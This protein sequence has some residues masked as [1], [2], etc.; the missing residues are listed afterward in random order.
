MQHIDTVCGIASGQ[1]DPL[2]IPFLSTSNQLKKLI[3]LVSTPI[4]RVGTADNIARVLS[5]R[6]IKVEQVDIKDGDIWEQVQA[7]LEQVVTRCNELGDKLAF[8]ANGGTKPMA[9]AAFELCFNDNVPVFYVDGNDVQWLYKAEE[10]DLEGEIIDQSLNLNMYFQSHGYEIEEQQRA[11]SSADMINL[12]ENWT[13]RDNAAEVAS[14]NYFAKQAKKTLS[15]KVDYTNLKPNNHVTD[16]IY[17]LEDCDLVT[18]ENGELVKFKSEDARFFANGGWYELYVTRL[19]ERINRDK[20]GGKGKV[21]S[22]VTFRPSKLTT[23]KHNKVKNE[24]DVVYLLGNRLFAFEC[25]TADLSSSRN[26]DKNRVDD[27]VYKLGTV[28]DNLGGLS[29]QGV[30]MS[31]RKVEEFDKERAKLLGI[32]IMEHHRDKNIMIDR[33]TRLIGATTRRF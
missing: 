24:F 10:L 13:E 1:P 33:L 5:L 30:V 14:L 2:I 9:M 16:L 25:K 22:N 17:E 15:V 32:E 18:F 26:T 19:L 8:N 12:I 28:I 4:K 27:A 6:G 31:Y 20:F 23:K 29:S 11:Q 3:L 7:S 21:L